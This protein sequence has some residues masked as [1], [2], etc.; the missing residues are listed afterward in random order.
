MINYNVP[1]NNR[2]NNSNIRA[3]VDIS[4]DTMKSHGFRQYN[5]RWNYTKDL[6]CEVSIYIGI[7][8]DCVII[9]VIDESF[10]QPYDYQHILKEHPEAGFALTVHRGVQSIMKRLSESGIIVGYVENDYI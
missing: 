10:C 2:G 6:G 1:I 3:G 9:D 7:L 4:D 8:L 5:S